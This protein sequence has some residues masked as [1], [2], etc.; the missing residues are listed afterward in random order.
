M[1]CKQRQIYNQI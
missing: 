1:K